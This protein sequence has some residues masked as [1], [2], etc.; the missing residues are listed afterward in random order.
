MHVI[1]LFISIFIF[2][3]FAQT[4]L[5]VLATPN[6]SKHVSTITDIQ[7]QWIE[8]KAVPSHH[9]SISTNQWTSQIVALTLLTKSVSN[10]SVFFTQKPHPHRV[11]LR[12]CMRAKSQSNSL[13]QPV[14]LL[15]SVKVYFTVSLL[16]TVKVYSV[17][18][19]HN[20]RLRPLYHT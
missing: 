19:I 16:H 2:V 14:N 9:S 1:S 7:L 17:A 4:E 20:S 15:R 8:M 3:S 6:R 5:R 11:F 12:N 10:E 13:C 18:F